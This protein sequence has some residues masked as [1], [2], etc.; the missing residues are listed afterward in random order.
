[1]LG[2]FEY[3]YKKVFIV[4]LEDDC[5]LLFDEVVLGVM[6]DNIDD[7]LEGKMLDFVIVKII[8]GWYVKIE[9]KCCLLIMVFDDF[10]KR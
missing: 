1:M 8:E 2:C 5:F 7:Y 10:W 6:Y 9:Y 4:D 3:L